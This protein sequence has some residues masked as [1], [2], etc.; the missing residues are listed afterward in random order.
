ML[1]GRRS[2]SPGASSRE[3][4]VSPAADGR[5][6]RGASANNG[7]I[8]SQGPSLLRCARW[9]PGPSRKQSV[10]GPLFAAQ[11]TSTSGPS[12]LQ[13]A[14]LSPRTSMPSRARSAAPRAHEALK[15]S[16]VGPSQAPP[17]ARCFLPPASSLQLP[18]GCLPPRNGINT[19]AEADAVVSVVSSR[20]R[21]RAGRPATPARISALASPAVP[22]PVP[23][24]AAQGRGGAPPA[25]RASNTDA[26][27]LALDAARPSA[28]ADDVRHC[29]Q[30]EPSKEGQKVDCLRS[31]IVPMISSW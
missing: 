24:P 10:P 27:S 30:K 21:P 13:S 16:C 25:V 8:T 28:Y 12:C 22:V 26:V 3:L 14:Q 19:S 7:Y 6:T 2:L 29:V 23:P 5:T 4:A 1:G 15:A 17:H 11:I 20:A 31:T 18:P 9:S